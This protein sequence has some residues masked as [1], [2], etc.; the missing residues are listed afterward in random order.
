MPKDRLP[1]RKLESLRTQGTLNPRPQDV[2]HR[3][4]QDNE[5]FDAR[6]AT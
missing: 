2:S 5:F 3:L 1:D 6:E 4:F